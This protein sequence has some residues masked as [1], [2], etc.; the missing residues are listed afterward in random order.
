VRVP[1]DATGKCPVSWRAGRA[2]RGALF[3]AGQVLWV[4]AAAASAARADDVAELPA[5]TVS[6]EAALQDALTS[7]GKLPLT[8]R[9]IPQSIT[10]IDQERM[11]EQG[12]QSL[13][14]VMQNTTGITVQ[15]YQLLT[16]AY[17]ARGFKVDA[18]ELDGV[19]VL[20]GNMAS[21]PQDMAV[22]KRVE[23]LRGANGLLHGAGNPAATVNLVRKR[24]QR[25]FAFDGSVSA[26][27]WD[28]YRAQVDLGGPLNEGGNVRGRM[29]AAYEDRGYFYDVADQQ[30]ALFYGVGEVDLGP[31]TVLSAGVQ[32]QRIRSTTNMAGVPRYADGGDIGLRR[33]TYLDV[34]WD[35][36]NWETTRLFADLEHR[37]GTGWSAKFSANYYTAHSDMKY[38]G[39]YG[40][41]DRA[42]GT[43]SRLMGAAYKFDNSQVNLDAYAS[44]PFEL[45]G[46]RH[47]LMI[48]AS[49]A[50]GTSEQRSA[51][52]TPALNVPV[53]VFDWDPHSVPEPGVGPYSSP[54]KT[55]LKQ[56]G[57]YGLTRISLADP[58]T[59]V[60]GGRMS[61]WNQSAPA[62]RQQI[63]PEFTPYGGIIVDLDRQWSL[64]GSYAQVFQPQG[65]QTR[66][67]RPLDPITGTNYEAGVKGELMEGALNVSMAIFQIQQKDRAQ[68]D[69]AWPCVGG[70]NCY[71][72]SGGEVRS[73]GVELEASG[74]I[75]PHWSVAAGYTYNTS[76]YLEDAVS[77]GQPFASFTPKHI[78]RLWSNYALPVMDRR[79]SVGAGL[80]MQSGYSTVAGPVTLRQ[81]GYTLVDLRMGYQFDKHL[82]ASLNVNNMF[83]RRYY[84]S[85]SGT[86]WNNR[87]GEPRSVMLTLRA[88]Y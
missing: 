67:G 57:I 30:S 88:R 33:S 8:V 82:S 19:P 45:L 13:D 73:R 74:R 39:A 1:I 37:F 46:R 60:L 7:V 42:T 36:F 9:E 70:R 25:A 64:Y 84:Q 34:D 15:P 31:D 86:A 55:L 87:Y 50:R 59:L 28:R 21:S 62:A 10:V 85:L 75:T 3:A 32:Y 49:A 72:I 48:G 71:Y 6:G 81:G 53:D 58:V 2:Q 27:S 44:G 43:G 5:V 16:T 40:A 47:E 35:R 18:F 69:P 76:K 65:E 12:L 29:V 77:G 61:W 4:A 11:R 66:D 63:D 56:Q 79:L 68:Q 26:G 52:L 14:E 24:P 38:A 41:I 22:Y 54:G 20:M 17:Y 23:I 83:D 51:A 78:F 80:R